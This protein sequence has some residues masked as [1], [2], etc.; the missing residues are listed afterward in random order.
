MSRIQG[1]ATGEAEHKL[2]RYE[3]LSSDELQKYRDVE[4]LWIICKHT[5]ISRL[6]HCY[7]E[8]LNECLT[9]LNI[10]N[11]KCLVSN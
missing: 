3:V 5:F 9:C 8:C 11:C 6:N 7:W 2:L 1:V 10:K 4:I